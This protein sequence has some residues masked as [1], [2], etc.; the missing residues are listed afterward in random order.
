MFF[1]AATVKLQEDDNACLWI[2][3]FLV[4]A[5]LSTIVAVYRLC[6]CVIYVFVL[7]IV[8][9]FG[10]TNTTH[11]MIFRCGHSSPTAPGGKAGWVH[12]FICI[13]ICIIFFVFW[14][15]SFSPVFAPGGKAGWVNR[16]ILL[17]CVIIFIS[18]FAHAYCLCIC[19]CIFVCTCI[20]IWKSWVDSSFR[21]SW[22][23]L[24]FFYFCSWIGSSFH[25]CLADIWFRWHSH[26]VIIHTA[27]STMLALIW[28]IQ[29][30]AVNMCI[31]P[32]FS[33]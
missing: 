26:Q 4:P 8:F 3:T 12:P 19:I 27:V 16:S 17:G 11:S 30:V 2:P 25:L 22:M 13:S 20:Q 15:V 21:C 1:L 23:C 31:S 9:V 6:I 5:F 32:Y 18:V 7:F 33:W 24:Y 28:S 10:R 14:S 29:L